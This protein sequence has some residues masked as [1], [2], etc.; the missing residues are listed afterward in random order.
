MYSYLYTNV[1]VKCKRKYVGR[2]ICLLACIYADRRWCI[3]HFEIAVKQSVWF[4]LCCMFLF[5]HV[6]VVAVSTSYFS[7]LYLCNVVIVSYA[8]KVSNS[9]KVIPYGGKGGCIHMYYSSFS[10]V[11]TLVEFTVL[12]CSD[13]WLYGGFCL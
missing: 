13:E 3:V 4:F 7:L 9:Q 2:S 8:F 5:K 6:V 12:L 1:N 11:K 10:T